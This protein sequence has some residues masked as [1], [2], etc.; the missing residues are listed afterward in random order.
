MAT[1]LAESWKAWVA[2]LWAGPRQDS[3]IR[4]AGSAGRA[5]STSGWRQ[6]IETMPDAVVAVDAELAVIFANR[7][8]RDIFPGLDVGRQMALADRSPDLATALNRALAERSS[9]SVSV[10]HMLP[11]E[12]RLDVRVCPVEARGAGL[13][14]LLV[15]VHDNSERDRLAQMRADFIAHASHELRTP[16]AALR[17]FVETL[18]GPARNDT[19]ARD[20][21]LG[22]MS[23]E[24]LR[25]TRILDDLLSLARVEMR[26]H[27]APTGYVDVNAVAAEVVKSL[28]SLAAAASAKLVLEPAA[29]ERIVRG[30]RDELVQ[31]L[32]N[33]VQNAIKY[34][35]AGGTV[36][37]RL[38]DHPA[39]SRPIIGVAVIDDGPGIAPA[40]LPRLTERFYRV[41]DKSSREKGGT[42]L[43]LAIVKHILT[44]HQGNLR[45]TSELGRGSTFEVELPL[46]GKDI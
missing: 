11:V 3:T 25:M 41:D 39:G 40:H 42:G 22:I 44:R 2:R 45:I 16:L 6:L 31:V 12:R 4:S 38:A 33:L 37:V 5:A 8:A 30:D 32:V 19:A 24:A 20:R 35:R 9:Q 27:I 43:G 46:V 21:F 28:E 26:A 36:I 10:H 18:Q 29:G 23:S 14:A 1:T 34:G 7:P 13:P 17:G 15:V